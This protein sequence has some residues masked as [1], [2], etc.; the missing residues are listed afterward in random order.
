MNRTLYLD[1]VP[2]P[3]ALTALKKELD[4]DALIAPE[5]IPTDQALSRVLAGPVI[6]RYSS[7]TFHAAAMDGIAVA[8]ETTFA[9]REGSPVRL[10]PGSG[11]TSVNTGNPLPEGRDAVIMAEHV[12]FDADGAA[13]IEAPAFPWQHVRRIGED[14]VATELVL[15]RGR[16][17]TA[18]DLAALLSAG[19]FE[20]EVTGTARMAVIPTGDEVLD[21]TERPVPGPGQV[22]ESNSVMLVNM[23]KNAGI[24]AERFAPVPDDPAALEAAARKA[25]AAGFNVVVLGAGSSAGTKDYTRGVMERLGRVVVH[26]VAAMPGK[27]ALLGVAENGSLL[28]GAPGYP[29]SAA[30]AF[31]KLVLPL[32]CWLEGRAAPRRARLPVR[33]ARRVPSRPGME[34][35]VRLAV[36]R[37]GEDY[38]GLPLAR[39]AGLIT[40]LTNA[41]AVAALPAACEGV[42]AGETVQA[43]LYVSQ[44][45]LDA[46]L[47]VVGSHDN[48]L[49]LLADALMGQPEPV[50]LASSHVG[51]MGGIA[52]L[53]SRQALC[54]GAHLFDPETNDFNF[55]FLAR[56]APD[57]D[58]AVIALAVRHQGLI[59][60]KG[61]PKNIAGVAD[62]ARPDVV[63]ANRQRGAGTRIL[64]DHHL[65]LAKIRPD[66]VRGYDKE[67]FTH[68]AVAVNV[69]TG[70]ADCGLGVYAAAKA[71]DLGFV[72]LARERYDLLIPRAALDD[73]R[74]AALLAIVR[75]PAFQAH[76]RDLGGY[77]T[78]LSGREMRPG[79]GLG[80]EG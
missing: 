79:M 16:T 28:A 33:L 78:D 54:A 35:F 17:L 68:M 19:V 2:I 72:P 37:V 4:R 36:G 51:S 34:E 11:F 74:I 58:V 80:G 52:A 6:A 43:E 57:L 13:L 15:P 12:T 32:C 10:S 64:L 56:H 55:P 67:E 45:E 29:V 46:T 63:F 59:V 73:P 31:E 20:V 41:Q 48:T 49:D 69:R 5:T 60:P 7:P 9:A 62:L 66:Q 21:Y 22:V 8:A 24:R 3:D 40:S 50:R 38:V 25:L 42:E 53:S 1:T 14:I 47:V 77:E 27:P 23:A 18:F 76:V 39:G 65:K 26:G 30:V 71:L 70:T 44:E 75:D 61:N